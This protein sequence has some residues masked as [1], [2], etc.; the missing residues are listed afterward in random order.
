MPDIVPI[1]REPVY[2]LDVDW[3]AF[4]IAKGL[5]SN[6]P[7][8]IRK[9]LPV[10]PYLSGLVP[11]LVD[12]WHN[13]HATIP[14]RRIVDDRTSIL[15]ADVDRRIIFYRMRED[16]RTVPTGREFARMARAM[17]NHAIDIAPATMGIELDASVA[18]GSR[19]FTYL[20]PFIIREYLDY[21]NVT[22]SVDGEHLHSIEDGELPRF[23]EALSQ[24]RE[25]Q[26][27]PTL[28]AHPFTVAR[29]RT[30]T[31]AKIDYVENAK[32]PTNIYAITLFDR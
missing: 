28:S 21:E 25:Q 5:P 18:G 26:F 9:S 20:N 29:I 17:G 23:V 13:D 24:Y 15:V 11:T 27:Q 30:I 32:L 19:R 22:I 6:A 16:L 2:K 4:E 12:I 8:R 1:V 14:L 31:D 3:R 10:I 7:K